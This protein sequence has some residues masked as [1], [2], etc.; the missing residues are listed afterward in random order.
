MMPKCTDIK[1]I[2]ACENPLSQH[3]YHQQGEWVGDK[4]Q[5]HGVCRYANGDEVRRTSQQLDRMTVTG[6]L[7]LPYLVRQT[8]QRCIRRYLE[9]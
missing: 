4:A 7:V 2:G 8:A 9:H 5:G 1:V 6:V 3:T